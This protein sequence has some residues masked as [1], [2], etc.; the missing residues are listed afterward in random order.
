MFQTL[1]FTTHLIILH[2]FNASIFRAK[3]VKEGS[4]IVSI[5]N[6]FLHFART[7]NK[8]IQGEWDKKW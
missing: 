3:V 2:S 1:F 7:I 4:S 5:V 6:Q 8:K